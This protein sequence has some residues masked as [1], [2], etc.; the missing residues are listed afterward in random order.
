MATTQLLERLGSSNSIYEH[1]VPADVSSSDFPLSH[2]RD[3]TCDAG[4]IV[5]VCLIETNPKES[6]DIQ[7][8]YLLKSLPLVAPPF[9]AFKVRTHF[10]YCRLS[11]LWR[12]ALTLQTTG[13]DG[14]LQLKVP[15]IT[16]D[17]FNHATPSDIGSS[18]AAVSYRAPQSLSAYLGIIPKYCNGVASS[19]NG[20]NEPYAQLAGAGSNFAT[21]IASNIPNSLPYGGIS[22][23]PFMMYQKIYRYAY[24]I[25]NLLQSNK[26]WFPNDLTDGWRINYAK[27][28]VDSKGYFCPES[29]PPTINYQNAPNPSPSVDDVAVDLLQL[30]YGLFEQDRFTTAIPDQLR[31]EA[32]KIDISGSVSV[33]FDN[34][35]VRLAR[36]DYTTQFSADSSLGIGDNISSSSSA[37]GTGVSSFKYLGFYLPETSSVDVGGTNVPA[38]SVDNAHVLATSSLFSGTWRHAGSSA[39]STSAVVYGINPVAVFPRAVFPPFAP[40]GSGGVSLK[41]KSDEITANLTEARFTANQL[42]SLLALSVWQER[43]MRIQA[44]DYNQYIHAHFN[45]NPRVDTHEPVYIGGTSDEIYFGEV[46]Q[47]SESTSTSPLGKV[48][49]SAQSQ[50]SGR[51]GHFYSPDYGY[52]MGVM[53]ISPETVYT[54]GVEKLWTRTEQPDFYVPENEGLGMEEILNREVFPQGTTVDD[55]LFGLQERN[56][57]YKSLPNKALGFFA[58]D[59]STNFAKDL[60]VFSQSRIFRSKPS[61]SHQF[62]VMSPNNIRRDMLV[63]PVMPMFRVSFAN[64]VRARRPMRYQNVPET[65]GF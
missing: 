18:T 30:R 11:D 26:I 57:E 17:G 8:K 63:S 6:F 21:R 61:L 1:D 46:V 32:P 14:T 31:G 41:M 65:F 7:V 4:A 29:A 34:A 45:S 38:G 50:G 55:L 33:Q 42:R 40:D 28:N 62:C 36:G 20:Y 9:T 44:G 49:G 5:P 2:K 10:Y 16:D 51:I 13:N 12:G 27:T 56:T 25:P 64:I 22:L 47:T 48:A 53:I 3:F 35:S 43:N 24:T 52:I 60:A 54:Q 19:D 39:S 37:G 23:L 59:D 58:F 15:V